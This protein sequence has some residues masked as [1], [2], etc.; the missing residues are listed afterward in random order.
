MIGVHRNLTALLL[1]ACLTGTAA[2]QDP[3]AD[4]RVPSEWQGHR[5]TPSPTD[6]RQLAVYQVM[7][8]RF[9]N[10]DHRNDRAHT[11][12]TDFNAN[13]GDHPQE[14]W[15]RTIGGD[16]KGLTEHLDYIK[17]LGFDIVWISAPLLGTEPN[18]YAPTTYG[19][20]DSK[21]G[22]VAEFR[23][24]IDEAHARGMYVIVDCVANHFA[25]WFNDHGSF[26]SNGY[27]QL[28]YRWPGSR[29]YGSAFGDPLGPNDFHNYGW[30]NDWN[31]GYQL[32]RGELVGLDDL[33]TETAWVRGYVIE[34]WSNVIKAFDIDGFRVDAIKH[35]R[36]QDMALMTEAWRRVAAS[37]G[38]QNFYMF[39]EAYSGSHG[40]VGYYTGDKAGTGK[41]IMNG[42]M[43][44]VMFLDGVP[45]R[46]F[47]DR[48]NLK[49]W[50]EGM[51]GGAYDM[52][53]GDG[54]GRWDFGNMNLHF[55]DNHDQPRFLSTVGDWDQMASVTALMTMIEGVG[56]LY[57]GSEQAFNTGGKNGVGAYPAMFDHPF[58]SGNANGDR[59]DMTY[60]LYKRIA[61]IM[62]ARRRIG[63][64][65]GYGT[66]VQDPQNGIFAFKRGGDALVAINGTG[67]QQTANL[68]FGGGTFVDLVSGATVQGARASVTLPKYGVAVFVKGASTGDLE[69]LVESVSPGHAQT[70]GDAEIKLVFDRDMDP[71]STA[72][73]ASV[74]P[75]AG[76]RWSVS[77]NTLTYT[78]GTFH[79]GWRY[80]VRVDRSARGTN[81]KALYGGFVSRFWSTGASSRPAV[82]S[83]VV[84]G[85]Q[86]T[87][88]YS[89]GSSV[90]SQSSSVRL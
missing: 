74:Y 26:G 44:Y 88:R 54:V 89:G 1:T 65:L 66:D 58:Q 57:Y 75:S 32:E 61:K 51:N 59:L 4:H 41:K 24:L 53:Q 76:G 87:F 42:M 52:G 43:D 46:L 45:G 18:G 78:G 8:D 21:L 5:H 22:T 47:N 33:K 34:K 6:W 71:S 27:G 19:I 68:H 81:G 36:V 25:N 56:S 11:F 48:W 35:V 64:A 84:G 16:F 55:A 14:G 83:P 7:T 60:W 38:K 3:W 2:A 50:I 30:V 69:P 63:V 39:G 29:E 15:R 9:S 49:R 40:A 13:P 23:R 28:S 77:G 73:A 79:A 70:S 80:T 72:A 62:R 90:G 20:L 86:V 67:G 31:D 82:A 10:G 37:V 85:N 12:S 17:S